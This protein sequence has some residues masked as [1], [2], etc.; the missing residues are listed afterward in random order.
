MRHNHSSYKG[1]IMILQRILLIILLVTSVPVFAM[2]KAIPADM[3]FNI[4]SPK[5]KEEQYTVNLRKALNS[6]V[7]V[8]I[9][10]KQQMVVTGVCSGSLISKQTILTAAHCIPQ[11]M[12]DFFIRVTF[13]D[14]PFLMSRQDLLS[15]NVVKIIP[16]P[17]YTHILDKIEKIDPI[18]FKTVSQY[19]LAILYINE[20][21][22]IPPTPISTARFSMKYRYII[23]AGFGE[24]AKLDINYPRLEAGQIGRGVGIKRFDRFY[25]RGTAEEIEAHMF[26]A[27][28]SVTGSSTICDGDSGGPAFVEDKNSFSIVGVASGFHV[29]AEKELGIDKCLGSDYAMYVFVPQHK[30][31]I[32]LTVEI[33]EAAPKNNSQ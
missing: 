15:Y 9:I 25:I 6:V 19:D 21:P 28:P 32:D 20:S 3:F 23:P 27:Y 17:K 10:H 7:L 33:L 31:W 24:A 18:I 1:K 11:N 8:E 5:I 30:Q 22:S 13:G 29:A 12:K 4:I 16:H 2:G 14:R 26:V